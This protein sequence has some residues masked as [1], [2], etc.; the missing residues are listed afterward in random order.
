MAHPHLY[1]APCQTAILRLSFNLSFKRFAPID[2]Q[3]IN[4]ECDAVGA[5]GIAFG[6]DGSNEVKYNVR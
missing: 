3:K 5:N 6:W 4:P 2:Q 1:F